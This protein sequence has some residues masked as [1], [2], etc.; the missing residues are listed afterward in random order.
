MKHIKNAT[1][2]YGIVVVAEGISLRGH[3]GRAADM[4][5]RRLNVAGIVNRTA[6]PEH[7]QRAGDTVATDRILA[8]AM[9]DA[10]LN[11]IDNN[12][13]YVGSSLPIELI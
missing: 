7:T 4:I 3:S 6:F 13:T 9:A 11:A 2:D 12:E 1:T 5:A 8:T 10:A